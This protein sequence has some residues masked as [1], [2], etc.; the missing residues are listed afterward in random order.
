[1][2]IYEAMAMGSP[3]DGIQ[4]VEWAVKEVLKHIWG[5]RHEISQD[6][7]MVALETELERIYKEHPNLA[8]V[9]EERVGPMKT[10]GIAGA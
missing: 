9:L 8:P 7:R 1:M 10:L 6:Q 4:P 2:K 5:S 3:D